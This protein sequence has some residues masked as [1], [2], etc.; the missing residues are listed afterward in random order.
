[1]EEEEVLE[2]LRH[3]R[4]KYGKKSRKRRGQAISVCVSEEEEAILRA[5]AAEAEMSF[6]EWAR[7]AMFKEAK[8]K[9]P[10]R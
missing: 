10:K 3:Q 8:V 1:M 4:G 6:S 5:A 2:L 7:R 9:I